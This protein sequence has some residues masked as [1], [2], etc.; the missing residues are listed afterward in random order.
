MLTSERIQELNASGLLAE[1]VGFETN[2][3]ARTASGTS[4]QTYGGREFV[5]FTGG[6]AVHACGHGHAEVVA[7]ITAQAAQVLHVSDIM[8]HVPQLELAQF[9]RE[10]F[11]EAIGGPEDWSF[12]L[13]NSGSESIDAAAKLALK[14]TGRKR[15]V[16][17]EGA[18]HGRTLFASAL[19]RSKSTHWGAYEP[20]LAPLRANIHHVAA[21]NC[22]PGCDRRQSTCCMN[23]LERLLESVGEEVAGVFFEPQQGEGGYIPMLPEVAQRLR[24]LTRQY[25]I[26]LIAD[27]IQSGFGRTGR[28]FGFE[29][30]GIAPDI[31]VFGK[32][33]GGGLPL[34]GVGAAHSLM[35]RW[36]PG[37]H[38]TTFGG[39]P[40][41]CAAGLAALRV[42][43]RE[44]L[45]ERAAQL[46]EAVKAR[47]CP[48][49][50]KYGVVD[51]RGN[52]LMIGVELRDA[53]GTPDYAR[54]EAV[55]LRCRAEGLLLLTCG[56]KIGNPLADNAAIRLIPPL[57]T[58]EPILWHALDLF[59][60]AL[61]TN[62]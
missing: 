8:R 1:V 28:W 6:I 13:M 43:Q 33:V 60:T 18:F 31:T 57:N 40:L 51:V 7:A 9:L 58:P 50:G 61:K 25:G 26:L 14:A 54:C 62:P 41:A 34:A 48:L 47:L 29:H 11:A 36:Q 16:A 24:A 30:L 38:G 44:G 39:N 12:L 52:G 4:V 27:E 55:K 46:G 49:V 20:F 23:S 42:V 53:D 5:D 3:V 21:P 22:K 37:E 17:F 2:E 35:G 32:A 59:E 45:V 15:F 56:A 10:R 19:S